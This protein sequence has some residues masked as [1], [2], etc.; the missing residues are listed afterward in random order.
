MNN[1]FIIAQV[2]GL[3]TI[4]FEFVSYQ[5][6]DKRKY[7]LVNGIGSLFWAGMFVSIGLATTFSTQLTLVIVGVYSATRALVF[8]WIFSKDT[9]KRRRAGKTFLILMIIVA[10]SAGITMIMNLPTREVIILQ[11]VTLVFALGFVVGQYLPGKHA[12]RISVFFYAAMLLLTQTPLNILDPDVTTGLRWNPV[13]I[14]IEVAKML[15]VVVFYI[16]FFYKKRLAI[17]LE[18]IKEVINCEASKIQACSNADEIATIMPIEKLEKLV[19]KMIRLELSVM[20]KDQMNSIIE[21]QNH[22]QVVL[23]DMKTVQDVKLLIEKLHRLKMKKLDQIPI[24]K[25]SNL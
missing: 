20:E 9:P 19:V 7:L 23:N 24:P 21:T 17:K 2:L 8:W 22:V 5:I 16:M 25:L 18:Q 13:G 1:W 12:L 15:S 11:A 4:I 6:K 3:V 14:L 10:L